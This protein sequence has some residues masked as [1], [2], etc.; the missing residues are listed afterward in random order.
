M[1]GQAPRSR[2]PQLRST[3]APERATIV[4]AAMA[5]ELAAFVARARVQQELEVGGCRVFLGRLG[6][7][8]VVLAQTGEGRRHA[9]RGST[10]LLERFSA[11]ALF[12]VGVAGGLSPSL[13]PGSLLVARRI[14]EG[15]K[16]MPR[17]DRVWTDRALRRGGAAAGT[18]VSTD[19]ILYTPASKAHAW[20]SLNEDG[21]AT[22]DLESAAFA[23]VAAR[24]GVPFLVV[25]AVCDPAEEELPFDFNRCRD[26]SGRIR[27]MRVVTRALANPIAARRLWD[28]RRRVASCSDRLAEFVDDLLNSELP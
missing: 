4:V 11:E 10:A 21:P 14:R 22:V 6:R 8:P 27:R 18:V 7:A 19:R 13:S 2:S 9:E 25:R 16:R 17:P 15:S 24:H 20:V 1:N 5:E 3:P 23:G 26:G 12:V 28:L